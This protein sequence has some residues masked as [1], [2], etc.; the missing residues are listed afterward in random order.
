MHE[1]FPVVAAAARV[2]LYSY[3]RHCARYHGLDCWKL[4]A[5]CGASVLTHYLFVYFKMF[6]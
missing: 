4:T 1:L 3:K 6:L 5:K 2:L